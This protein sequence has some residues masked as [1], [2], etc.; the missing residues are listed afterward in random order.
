M[1]SKKAFYLGILGIYIGILLKIMVFKQV[2]TIH[3][4]HMMFKFGGTQERP[5][6]LIPF[7]TIIPYLL[8][9]NGLLIGALNIGGNIL[10]LVPLGFLLPFIFSKINWKKI[11]L[12]APLS[13]LCVELL[14]VYL[15]V[16]IFD[17]DDVILNGLGVILGYAIFKNLT[18]INKYKAIFLSICGFFLLAGIIFYMQLRN[19]PEP[20]IRPQVNVKKVDGIEIIDL[21]G[22]TG[23]TGEIIAIKK[24]QLTLKRNDGV[25]EN[26]ILNS[27]TELKSSDGQRGLGIIKVGK[28][29]TVVVGERK[30]AMAIFICAEK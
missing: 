20:K 19:M 24:D 7:S 17:I 8:G 22:G 5:A 14:Q 29:A 27:K 2:D 1:N 26:I 4:G 6:N 11:L 21:C 16:G 28:R 10:L 12:I 9:R 25:Q 3:V 13:G 18:I 23:G 30:I 15:H